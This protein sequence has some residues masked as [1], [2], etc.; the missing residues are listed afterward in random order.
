MNYGLTNTLP[1]GD[2]CLVIG[3]FEEEEKKDFSHAL[4]LDV[5]FQPLIMGL[6][7]KLMTQGDCVWQ[8]DHQGHSLCVVHCG[9]KSSYNALV[10]NKIMTTIATN[11]FAQHVRSVVIALPRLEQGMAN[12]QLQSMLIQMESARYQF[13]DYKTT[14]KKTRELESVWFHVKDADMDAL[15]R[16]QS[17]ANGMNF[18]RNLAN[19]PANI[20][21]PSYLAEQ[22]KILANQFDCLTATIHDHEALKKMGLGALL[23][24]GQGSQNPP[25]LIEMHYEGQKDAP[26]VVLVGKGITFDSGGISLKPPAGMEEMKFDMAGAASVL[27]VLKACALLRLPIRVVGLLACAEN[28]PSGSAVK[29]GDVITSLSGQTIEITN[30]DAEGRL[31]LSDALTFAA[32]FNPDYVLDIATLTGAVIIALGHE[33]TGFMANDETL[34]ECLLQAANESQ[35]KAWRL[36]LDPVYQE[37]LESPIADILNSP[38]ERIAGS[39]I[40]GSFLARFT[41]AYRWAHLDIAGTAWVSGKNRCATGRPVPLLMRLLERLIDAR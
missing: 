34:A 1:H 41:E 23:A 4:K 7:K 6:K 39:I 24:V 8:A 2:V 13:L 37:S 12:D 22:A 9:L 27:G 14:S 40:G 18:A 31:V 35:D 17:I 19:M 38:A 29:P 25:R 5:S 15:N 30:T 26:L 32:R 36:P 10:L 11:L 21:T 33:Y 20:C 3:V 28:M 16:A